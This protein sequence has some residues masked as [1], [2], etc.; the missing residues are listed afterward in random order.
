M[1][2]SKIEWTHHTFNP[3]WGCEKVSPACAHCYAEA[4]AKRTGHNVWG[5]AKPRRFFGDAHWADPLNW[6]KA[7][8]AAGERQ[9]VFCGS[10]CDIF[11]GYQG[12]DVVHMRDDRDRLLE[13]VE[14]TPNLD[15]LFLTKR[16]ENMVT[17][18]DARWPGR[19]PQ[20]VIAMTTVEN[21]EQAEIRI[22]HLLK[23]PALRR[24]L[25]MEPLLS[26]VQLLKPFQRSI[27]GIHWVIVGGESGAGEKT[28]LTHPTWVR[29][30]RDECQ[31]NGVAF[32]FKQWGDWLPFQMGHAYINGFHEARVLQPSPDVKNMGWPM[33]R[34]GK[35]KAGRLLDG[36]EWNEY[37]DLS[38]FAE[39]AVVA[40]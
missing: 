30:L 33:Y 40:A 8:E 11:E 18:T 39:P 27:P 4:F 2:N 38:R 13:L 23:V 26:E 28:R 10:M 22:P 16:P 1:K 35:M 17:M 7:A 24:A 5:A 19:W 25:S 37:A 9:R 32:F 3:W 31:A 20:N 29:S 34:V 15:W 6:D 21:Q 36:R 12:P 14:R